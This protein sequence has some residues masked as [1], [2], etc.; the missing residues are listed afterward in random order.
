M[1]KLSLAENVNISSA[2]FTNEAPPLRMAVT[3][4]SRKT[5]GV[6]QLERDI[7]VMN[8]K[9]KVFFA[10]ALKKLWCHWKLIFQAYQTIDSSIYKKN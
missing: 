4:W 6:A 1:K 9:K 8:N 3:L 5:P 7:N 10:W 2:S